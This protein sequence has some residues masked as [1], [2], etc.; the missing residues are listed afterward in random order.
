MECGRWK[1]Y[2]GRM[3]GGYSTADDAGAKAEVTGFKFQVS[4]SE[5]QLETWN[6]QPET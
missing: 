4:S 3:K 2:A 5:L 1:M 6:M